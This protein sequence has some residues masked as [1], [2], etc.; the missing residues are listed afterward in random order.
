M[1]A[2]SVS[3]N[4]RNSSGRQG[5]VDVAPRLGG[6]RV[7]VVA[8][9]DDLQRAGPSDQPGQALGSAAAGNDAER[10]FRLGQPRPAQRG[11]AHVEG[12]REFAAAAAGD[13]LDDGDR[14]LRHG[15]EGLPK[16]MERGDLVVQ[17]GVSG[18][19]L[20]DQ[21]DVGVRH[22]EVRIGRIDD[23]HAH[24]VVVADLL[25]EPGELADEVDVQQ[26]DRR[27]VH[28]GAADV[29]GRRRSE[30]SWKPS[31]RMDRT[32]EHPQPGEVRFSRRRFIE[33]ASRA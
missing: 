8:S 2:A 24:V 12:H 19:Q 33:C 7:D 26:I 28:G 29:V 10:D 21:G 1:R 11:E 31:Y 25:G 30:G 13:A 18:G 5:P 20:L 14:R 16:R 15:A 6:R 27:V 9:E 22:E 23:D 4:G 3:T 32:L 17:R